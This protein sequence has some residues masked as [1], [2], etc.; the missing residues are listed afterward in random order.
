MKT[1]DY[2]INLF[3]YLWWIFKSFIYRIFKINRNV[4]YQSPKWCRYPDTNDDINYCWSYAKYIDDKI[5]NRKI[6]QSEKEFKKSCENCEFYKNKK[7][8]R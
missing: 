8:E 4:K 3:L 5:E 1:G 7:E 2:N 6:R